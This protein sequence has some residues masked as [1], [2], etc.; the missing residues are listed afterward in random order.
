MRRLATALALTLLLPA[1]AAA[2]EL[3]QITGTVDGAPHDWVVINDST[4]RRSAATTVMSGVRQVT[5]WGAA[6][7]DT[8]ESPQGALLLDFSLISVGE[9]MTATDARLQYLKDGYKSGYLAVE[10]GLTQVTLSRA[11]QRPDG[12]HL[13]GKF[14][15]SA[16]FSN[17]I[18]LRLTAPLP[19]VRIDGSFD[20]VLP[21]Q[22]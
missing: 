9:A 5:L 22:Q 20:V 11:E 6:S 14:S 13:S 3:G 21:E 1:L 4:S 12:L 10:D 8:P 7:A 2:G 18:K 15:A 16:T 19:A 17:Q